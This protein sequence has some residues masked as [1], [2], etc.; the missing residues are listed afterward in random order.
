MKKTFVVPET[1]STYSP[2]V[3]RTAAVVMLSAPYNLPVFSVLPRG[4][5]PIPQV[6]YLRR[7][8]FLVF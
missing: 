5:N 7:L 6:V 4:A 2:E 1:T 8:S 3:G